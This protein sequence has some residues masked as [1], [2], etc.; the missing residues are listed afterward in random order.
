MS[1]PFSPSEGTTSSVEA[2]VARIKALR[3]GKPPEEQK[4]AA[5]QASAPE[6]PLDTSNAIVEGDEVEPEA[7]EEEGG[8]ETA[9]AAAEETAP[10]PIETL[11][12]LAK[13]FGTD[14]PGLASQIKVMAP[15]GTSVPLA[16]VLEAHRNSPE[17]LNA[18]A[19]IAAKEM[20]LARREIAV[21]SATEERLGMLQQA[22]ERLL[23]FMDTQ[24]AGVDLAALEE[25]NPV[26]F[27]RIRRQMDD[28]EGALRHA[29]SLRD[30][31]RR[32]L[33]AEAERERMG[34]G[35][36]EAMTLRQHPEWRTEAQA[37]ANAE[38]IAGYLSAIGLSFDDWKGDRP[39][40]RRV[41]IAHAAAK[42][43][44]HE[45]KKPAVLRKVSGLPPVAV[46]PGVRQDT[47]IVEQDAT[48]KR[49]ALL[50]RHRKEKSVDS[51][52]ALVRGLRES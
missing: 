22:S 21:R 43:W 8:E 13:A 47:S 5:E 3:D 29:M 16:A 38:L 52:V 35:E 31:E 11:D 18:R 20:E 25:Q 1:Q 48:R 45:Q 36:K 39:D 7:Q 40:H 26:E 27:L 15:D 17:L 46:R 50:Q 37:R 51:A 4:P 28:M 6:P 10:A 2:A 42:Q 9:P 49:Q 30:G 19:Q 33:Q 14:I 32:A 23:G 41:L 12:D 34:A 44:A 24:F